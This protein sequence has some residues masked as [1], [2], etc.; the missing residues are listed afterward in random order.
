MERSLAS[1][2]ALSTIV[3]LLLLG[4]PCR[5]ALIAGLLLTYQAGAVAGVPILT[6]AYLIGAVSLAGIG[7]ML[8]MNPIAL[9]LSDLLYVLMLIIFAAST[10]WSY[11]PEASQPLLYQLLAFMATSY[12]LGRLMPP[13]SGAVVRQA[14]ICM[15]VAGAVITVTMLATRGGG[16]S[17]QGTARL[18]VEG[19]EASA[20]GL[21]QFFPFAIYSAIFGIFLTRS[22]A[23]RILFAVSIPI[24]IYGALA[25]GTRGVFISLIPAIVVSG[26]LS[27]PRMRAYNLLITCIVATVGITALMIY[28]PTDQISGSINRILGVG[29]EGLAT[30]RSD[31]ERQQLFGVAWSLIGARPLLGIGYGSFGAFAMYPYPHNIWLEVAVS[32]G[33]IGL[34]IVL[35]WLAAV[36]SDLLSG[37]ARDKPSVIFVLGLLTI[38][39]AQLQVSFALA[40]AKPLFLSAGLAAAW[41]SKRSSSR[42]SRGVNLPG[43]E[44]GAKTSIRR[45]C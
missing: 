45:N 40:F 29:V 21:A 12:L 7:C 5:G 20:V 17:Y 42:Q 33:V 32:V 36:F 8:K 31:G 39:L 30:H 1:I 44:G 24:L 11:D 18:V 43:A 22:M 16:S 41:A 26:V 14:A 15:A 2:V 27:V 13:Q 3:V 9:R 28:L 10:S 23:A 6:T 38:S 34:A 37:W 19:S 4:L 35:L 25:A